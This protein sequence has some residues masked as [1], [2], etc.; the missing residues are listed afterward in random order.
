MGEMVFN[1][2]SH[3]IADIAG[4]F[5]LAVG[6]IWILVYFIVIRLIAVKNRFQNTRVQSRRPRSGSL[7]AR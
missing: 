2:R 4:L 1:L 3:N 7:P 6:A 5:E